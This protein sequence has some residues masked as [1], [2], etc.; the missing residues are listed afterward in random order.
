MVSGFHESLIFSERSAVPHG[1]DY[2]L[3][4]ARH[5]RGLEE[6]DFVP[7]GGDDLMP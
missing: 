3:N 4:S 6:V 2:I 5:G 1:R 7:G